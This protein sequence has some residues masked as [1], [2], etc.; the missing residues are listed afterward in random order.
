MSLKTNKSRIVDIEGGDYDNPNTIKDEQEDKLQEQQTKLQ[1]QQTELRGC[2]IEGNWKEVERLYNLDVNFSTM[3][4]NKSI[5]TAL[6]MAVN[7]GNESVVRSLVGSILFHRNVVAFEMKNGKGDTPLHLAASRGFQEICECI[8]GKNYERKDLID[9]DNNNKETPF[10]LASLFCQKETFLYLLPFVSYSEYLFRSNGDSILHCAILGEYFDLALKIIQTF[11]KLG[12]ITNNEGYTPLKLL[13]TRP[14]A[15]ESGCKMTW[16]KK[17][18]YHYISVENLNIEE[19]IKCYNMKQDQENLHLSCPKNYETCGF[20][21]RKCQLG[22]AKLP[23][24]AHIRH[25]SNNKV[26]EQKVLQ[27]QQPHIN[28]S[29]S[30]DNEENKQKV[31]SDQQQISIS[32]SSDCELL[33]ENYATCLWFLKFAYI[34]ILGLFG[35]GMYVSQIPN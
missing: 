8:I 9:I 14:S 20:F 4:I 3:N 22:I 13:A 1:K 25:A 7:E 30:Y 11:P 19:V 18:L 17:I 10:F 2:T 6:H 24:A 31:L 35:V 32:M 28:I 21:L 29:M 23:I 12:G 16:W 15:F 5:G 33:P 34:Y 26:K 27:D